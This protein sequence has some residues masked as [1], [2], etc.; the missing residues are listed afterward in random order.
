MLI[1]FAELMTPYNAPALGSAIRLAAP[2]QRET[3]APRKRVPIRRLN[4]HSI[5]LDFSATHASPSSS[6]VLPVATAPVLALSASSAR[7]RFNRQ[8]NSPC[9]N[10]RLRRTADTHDSA[11]KKN[12]KK[13][14]R[15]MSSSM[16][17]EQDENLVGGK[18]RGCRGGRK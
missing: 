1:I 10:K 4:R 15:H 12:T 2:K 9:A 3:W 17:K 14:S 16:R 8:S 6:R 18:Q 7:R 11:Y 13:A 5:R